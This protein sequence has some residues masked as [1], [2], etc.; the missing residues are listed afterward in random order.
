VLEDPPFHALVWEYGDSE[1]LYRARFWIAEFRRVN[2]IRSDV[3]ARVW[4]RLRRERIEPGYPVQ[5]HNPGAPAEAESAEA[6]QSA[7]ALRSVD[8]FEPLSEEERILLSQRLRPLLFG[9]GETVI[10]QGAAGDSLFVITRG[11]VEVRVSS[12]GEERVVGT[13]SAG[14]FFGEMSLLTGDPRTATVVALE[15]AEVLPVTRENFRGIAAAN[16][17]VLEAVARIVADRRGR[18]AETIRES[19]EAAATRSAAHRDLL[20]RVRSFFSL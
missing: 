2:S 17:A 7:T 18:L 9:R 19:E 20:K 1:I 15:D 8:L 11:R 3:A 4:Y 6:V 10:R 14:S 5:I 13:L 12:A 16:P